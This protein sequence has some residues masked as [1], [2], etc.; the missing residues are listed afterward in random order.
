MI[1]SNKR[2]VIEKHSKENMANKLIKN[3]GQIY[4]NRKFDLC[5]MVF[6]GSHIGITGRRKS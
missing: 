5:H 4:F 3:N 1:I 6:G 2:E